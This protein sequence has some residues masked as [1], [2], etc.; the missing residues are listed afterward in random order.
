MGTF[1]KRKSELMSSTACFTIE[2]NSHYLSLG[3]CVPAVA[4][5]TPCMKQ[6]CAV[7]APLQGNK[8]MHYNDMD[9]FEMTDSD[10]QKAH[11]E[12]RLQCENYNKQS[13]LRKDFFMDEDRPESDKETVDRILAGK[14]TLEEDNRY[15]T[16]TYR[17]SWRDPATPKD[18]EGYLKAYEKVASAYQ[19]ARDELVA[20]TGDKG[21]DI[22]RNFK[23]ATFH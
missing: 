16:K 13:Q 3:N 5:A 19:D 1:E 18:A 11:F 21:L 8:K 12:S 7:Q 22:L 14:Y 20:S 9:E 10:R 4:T 17:I 23:A 6:D 15:G 2:A